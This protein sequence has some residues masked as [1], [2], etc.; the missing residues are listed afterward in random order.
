[1][2]EPKLDAGTT[3]DTM[4]YSSEL[5][6][7]LNGEQVVILNPDPA[8]LLVDYLH[9]AGLTGT[10]VGC[11]EGGC[12]AC[13]VMLSHYDTGSGEI[14][15]R[16]VNSCLRPLCS[17]DGMMVTTVEGIGSVNDGMDPAQFSIAI[18]NGSQCGFCTPGFVMNMHSF[19]QQN[20]SF[21]QAETEDLFGGN[22]CRCTGY[23][24]ILR[25][26][27]ES[28]CDFDSSADCS[29]KCFADPS[30]RL[31]CRG[32]LK[33][34]NTEV[35]PHPDQGVERLHFSRENRNWYRPAAL[36]ELL[37]LK[38]HLAEQY[39]PHSVGLVFG[40]TASGI[41]KH[42]KPGHQ[43]DISVIKELSLIQKEDSG[44]TLGAAVT[45]QKLIDV[46]SELIGNHPPEKM[47]GIA[48]LHRHSAYIAGYQV[49]SAG[50]IAGNIFIAKSHAKHG[51]PFP[52]DLFTVFGALGVTVRIAS[53]EYE[54]GS[55]DFLLTEMPDVEE[56]PID[57]LILHFHFPFT[58]PSEYVQTHRVAKRTQMAHP[59]VNAGFRVRL[60]DK[61]AVHKGEVT[62]VFGGLGRLNC[63]FPKTESFLSEKV[64]NQDTLNA[65]LP[66]LE[67]E[68]DT[69]TVP[70]EGE[71]ISIEYRRS[72]ALN[73]FYK[74]YLHVACNIDPDLVSK[75]NQSAANHFVRPLSTGLQEHFEYPELYPLTQP[76][77]KRAAFVQATGECRYTQDIPL[78]AGGLHGV[79][80]KSSRPHAHFS[81]TKN[82]AGLDAL[83]ELLKKEFPG[84]KA[85][86]TVE[87][88]PEDGKR[89]IGPSWDDP[90]FSDGIVTCVGA[91]IA[92]AVA[93]T[94]TTAKAAAEFVENKCIEYKNLP[95]VVTLEDAILKNTEMPSLRKT[96]DPDEDV[97]QH[98]PSIVRDGTDENW[99]KDFTSVLPGAEQVTG[100]IYTGP[101]A[102]FYMETM[103]ALAVPG[104]YEQMTIFNSTQNP[105]GNQ[106]AVAAV[107]GTKA[108]QINLVCDQIGGGFGGKQHRAAFP[109][110][111]A[112][113]A[114]RKLKKPVRLLYDRPTDML[115]VGKRHPYLGQYKIAFSKDGTI[116]GACIDYKGEGGDSYDA[117]FPVM[118]LSLLQADGCYN[119]EHF[120][121][122]GAVYRTNKPS[123]TAFRTFGTVQAYAVLEDAVEQV[124]HELSH[125]LKRKVLPEE[126]REKNLYR[127]GTEQ[128]FDTT[129]HGQWL[130]FC[131]IREIW[132][133]V[134]ESSDFDNRVKAVEEFNCNNRWRKRGISMIPFK[135]G[136]AFT[137]P[138]GALNAASALV[139][140]N[141]SDGSVLVHHGA[142]EMGQ[143]VTTKIAQLAAS[144]LGIP[145]EYIRVAGNSS[146]TISNCPPT[147]A[148]TGYDLGGGAVEKACRVLRERLE[149]FCRD[150]EQFNPHDCVD[151]W[152][153]NWGGQW[154]E[155]IFK[156]WINRVNLSAAECYKNPH[157]E[158]ATSRHKQGHP[159][160]YFTYS[161]VVSE[162][163]IDVLTG[164]Y[165]ILR[166]DLLFDAGKSPNPAIDIGQLEGG[167]V[168]SVGFATT[169]ELVYDEHGRLLTDNIWS[170]KPPCT[171]MIPIDFRVGLHKVNEERNTREAKA[172]AHAIKS[173]KALGETS[174]MPGL[175]VYF[176]LKH[177]IMEARKEQTGEDDWIRIDLPATCQRIQKNCG[178]SPDRFTL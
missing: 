14:V 153:L 169:E 145:L 87:D 166:A 19:M 105:N 89:L 97:E 50:S 167:Y 148:S 37:S 111:Q 95:A 7:W 103:C 63:R 49:R 45:I 10:K 130:K 47:T 108:N 173:A 137:E 65:V 42:E 161:T 146:D 25:A 134:K 4:S 94:I 21:S 177:A 138:R 61:K 107:L 157:Y 115:M 55:K 44:I 71:G 127:D 39:G 122:S 60:N 67:K 164:E 13:T 142:V 92:L 126:I 144:T 118:D 17:L 147:A 159:F 22:L 174:M 160:L 172:E 156:S 69:I 151:N 112:A 109:A 48:E 152:R 106:A 162:V 74:F 73:L 51:E 165:V 16:P 35:L 80:V 88:I 113:V 68:I 27:R 8:L 1:M 62:L 41:Y 52:S 2:R 129:P 128:E 64:W 119:Y 32:E 18:N 110:C 26:A 33:K 54:G 82:V 75:E 38:K 96:R 36:S 141:F 28:A 90:V 34:I 9:S 131:N 57:A 117:S 58:Q 124:A 85:L 76:I 72:L 78:P 11:G 12:G 140:I 30:L 125:K 158:G 91:P 59:I 86:I 53:L 120:Q 70:S 170:Y 149:N 98:I 155:I 178:V 132:Q 84:F 100:S 114:A 176:A 171:K 101:Q 79:M 121:S 56:L 102:H 133:K 123:F 163:E 29:Q 104:N 81:F 139:N 20:P 116:K 175:T 150:L 6:F 5:V 135:Y 93:E 15:H 154:Q 136:I 168:Q 24:P 99:V 77:I 3:I 43:I 31:S 66:V 83:Q 143:G 40:H 46:T 23:R